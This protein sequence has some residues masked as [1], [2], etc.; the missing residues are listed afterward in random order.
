MIV[1]V[2][3]GGIGD[4]FKKLGFK[5]PK[6]LIEVEQK[7]ILF[8]LL[9]NLNLKNIDFVY[10]PYNK[11]Y[12]KHDFEN[13]VKNK[14]SGIK[15]K[16]LKLES[17]T[18]GAAETLNIAI[19][20]LTY[21]D[22]PVLCVDSDNFYLT[23][24][25]N[26]WNGENKIFTFKD[27]STS[28]KFSYVDDNNPIQKIIE[29]E[30][31]S[32]L[33]CCGVYGFD[34]HVTL[35]KYCQKIIDQDI[36]QKE[37]FYTSGVIQEMI[38]DEIKFESQLIMNKDY[39]S[40]GTPEQVDEFEHPFLFDLDG[41][42]VNTDYIYVKVWNKI[43]KKY[44]LSIDE[45]F[46]DFFIQGK[47]DLSFLTSVFPT[48]TK[49]E[50]IKISNLKD[51]LFIEYLKYDNND[52]MIEGAKTFIE[53]NKNRKMAIITS[54][55]KVAATFIIEKIQLNEYMQFIIA[56]EDC[57][58]HK[59]HNEPYMK[60]ISLLNS[61]KEKCFIFEDSMS[62]YK[63][64]KNVDGSKITLII[65]EN[66]KTIHEHTNEYKITNYNDFDIDLLQHNNLE[67]NIKNM[68]IQKL[69]LLPIKNIVFD[70]VSMK[71]G[72]IC[73]IQSLKIEYN[74]K[75]KNAVLKIENTDNELSNVA[76][77]IDL[78]SNENYFYK[79]LANVINIETPYCFGTFILDNKNTIIME[80]LNDLPGTFNIDL[81][82]NIDDILNIVGKLVNM[83]NRFCF[84]NDESIILS[85]QKINKITDIHYY[86]ELVEQRFEKFI[87]I[88]Q[89]LFTQDETKILKNI[90]NNYNK[91][92][93]KSG[94][95]PLN[96]CH[97]D[98][99][100]ANIFFKH[101]GNLSVPI[102]LDWQYIHLNKGIS[103]IAFLLV[104]STEYNENIN[105]IIL[106]YYFKKSKMYND[107]NDFIHDFKVSLCIFP[108]FVM[109]WFNTENRDCLLD[110]VFP[111]RFMKNVL[112][113][114]NHYLDDDFFEDFET[115]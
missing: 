21:P 13:I 101:V 61:T 107:Y 38:K 7:P 29:K 26:L 16:F 35:Q 110:K 91:I 78:Y 9:D 82:K 44:N 100:S 27:Y 15:F 83:H 60:G 53:T 31:I 68:I 65:H 42:L 10:I 54:C 95:F 43:M 66:N 104:E 103:D 40:L 102:F 37:E 109:V 22:C 72:Y 94:K 47:N 17:N 41:T 39:F 74:D 59:P 33:A 50:V 115:K 87:I 81:N 71:T 113:F 97:G 48:I 12:E 90:A 6:A 24:I 14:Y 108:F 111:I 89:Q 8:H 79:E 34:S 64:A 4:R 49:N 5:E 84:D 77:K 105:N 52:I 45:Q 32:D 46:F 96:F 28:N 57:V 62:G 112:K 20:N 3:L 92:V 88:N 2:P 30:K 51:D 1:I 18:R 86:N 11:E 75:S 55:N 93:K 58:N 99:K 63:S 80:N 25:V 19:Q 98:A 69:S 67:N 85:M 70:N 56:A 23:D 36:R 76:K 106:N 73:D 114:Y